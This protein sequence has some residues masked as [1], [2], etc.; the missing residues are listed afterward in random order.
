MTKPNSLPIKSISASASLTPKKPSPNGPGKKPH[1][2]H[3]KQQSNQGQHITLFCHFGVNEKWQRRG[4]QISDY[5]KSPAKGPIDNRH[6]RLV[7]IDIDGYAFTATHCAAKL[8]AKSILKVVDI[9]GTN[10]DRHSRASELL[11]CKFIV[12]V[13]VRSIT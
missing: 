1:T 10:G 5:R 4:N 3:R 9:V 8:T 7:R 11:A 13:G 6:R 12:L 2:Y